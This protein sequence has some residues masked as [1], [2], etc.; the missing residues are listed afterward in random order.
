MQTGLRLSCCKAGRVFL[1]LNSGEF[2]AS[3]FVH[4]EHQFAGGGGITEAFLP[5]I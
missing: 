5:N 4:Q 1:Q 3:G 2:S